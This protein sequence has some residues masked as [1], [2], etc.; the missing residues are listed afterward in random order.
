M[1][2]NWPSSPKVPWITLNATSVPAGTS[3]LSPCTSTG[4]TFAPRLWSALTTPSPDLSDTFRSEPGPPISTATFMPAISRLM[5]VFCIGGRYAKA[6]RFFRGSFGDSL[7]F[8]DDLHLSVK[9]EGALGARL[10]LDQ[11]DEVED[12]GGRG[13]AIVDDEV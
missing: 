2:C 4:V 8:A 3:K 12:V 13:R 6:R 1:R 11:R 10:L 9:I 5:E 7:R